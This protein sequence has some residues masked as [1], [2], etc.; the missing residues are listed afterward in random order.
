MRKPTPS[1]YASH[2]WRPAGPRAVHCPHCGRAMS[3]NALARA[4]HAVGCLVQ[5]CVACCPTPA[6]PGRPWVKP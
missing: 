1:W 6:K 5:T 4:S 3:S 2:Y